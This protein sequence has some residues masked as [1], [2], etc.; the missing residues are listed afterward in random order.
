MKRKPVLITDHAV[1]RFLERVAGLDIE[2]LR[3]ALAYRTWPA[4]Q[5]GA[6][7]LVVGGHRYCLDG[8]TLITVRPVKRPR[9]RIRPEIDDDEYGWDEIDAA[10]DGWECR[11]E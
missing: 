8:N 2:A 1:V 5:A 7:T 4:V 9:P 10:D 3:D 11:D 6:A